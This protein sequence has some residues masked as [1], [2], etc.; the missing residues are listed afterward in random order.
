MTAIA[1]LLELRRKGVTIAVDRNELD[2]SAPRGALSP[3]LRAQLAEHKL[4]LIRLLGEGS[5]G[6]ERIPALK[7]G[8]GENA[9]FVASF[10]QQRLWFVNQLIPNNPFYNIPIAWRLTGDLNIGA[11]QASL[12]AL[13]ARHETLRTTFR[14][15]EMAPLQVI[16][17]P[18]PGVLAIVDLS[19]LA[20][21]E[22]REEARCRMEAEALQPFDLSTGP[23][24]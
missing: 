20:E 11:L 1:L 4:E 5:G 18:K 22:R 10:A 19:G 8:G 15:D 14:A 21:H 24:F 6:Q 3:E 13:V 17:D 23:L 2:I 9:Q 12:D 16:S 7:R